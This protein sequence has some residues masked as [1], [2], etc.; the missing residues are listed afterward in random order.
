[1]VRVIAAFLSAIIFAGM[2]PGCGGGPSKETI[3]TDVAKEWTA[4]SFDQ[5]SEELIGLI[6]GEAPVVGRLAAGILSDQINDN[7]QWSYS[8]PTR[9]DND[10]YR[11]TAS[12]K[13]KLTVSV[14]LLGEK[15]Y[16][17]SLPLNLDVDTKER[18]VSNWS[19]D[20]SSATAGEET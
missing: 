8:T 14:P 7:I 18:A 16:V 3:A 13:I 15:T 12:A 5:V 4:T 2:V 10:L 17:S 19:S 1:M 6:V 9:L 11:T 20:F